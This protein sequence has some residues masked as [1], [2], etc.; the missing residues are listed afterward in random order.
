MRDW[1]QIQPPASQFSSLEITPARSPG[2]E[3]ERKKQRKKEAYLEA[4][5]Q[6]EVGWMAVCGSRDIGRATLIRGDRE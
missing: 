1:T 4:N 5:G 3:Q 2:A 6:K